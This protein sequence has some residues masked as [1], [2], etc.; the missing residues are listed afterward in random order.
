MLALKHY[1][2]NSVSVVRFS[3]FNEDLYSIKLFVRTQMTEYAL[4]EWFLC[5]KR[6]QTTTHEYV[7]MENDL[8]TRFQKP[9]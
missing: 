6:E 1:P 2:M 4:N 5:R 3:F 7:W 8:D 9:L